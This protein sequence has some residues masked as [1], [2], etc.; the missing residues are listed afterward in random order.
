MGTLR[1]KWS[2]FYVA[3]KA[4]YTC[5]HVLKFLEA[6]S[7]PCLSPNKLFMLSGIIYLLNSLYLCTEMQPGFKTGQ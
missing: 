4:V 7:N 1:E 6:R 5:V 2:L 3:A